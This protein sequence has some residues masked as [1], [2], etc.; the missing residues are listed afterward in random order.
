MSSST[1]CPRCGSRQ[2]ITTTT[3]KKTTKSRLWKITERADAGG[4]RSAPCTGGGPPATSGRPPRTRRAVPPGLPGPP[5]KTPPGAPRRGAASPRDA[6]VQVVLAIARGRVERPG[7]VDA[8]QHVREVRVTEKHDHGAWMDGAG[9]HPVLE[10]EI[11]PGRS[12]PGIQQRRRE[13]SGQPREE[14]RVDAGSRHRVADDD[15]AGVHPGEVGDP[16]RVE[17]TALPRT[18]EGR[19]VTGRQRRGRPRTARG[20]GAPGPGGEPPRPAERAGGQRPPQP[21]STCQ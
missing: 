17:G 14:G 18:G 3:T 16:P 20:P 10:R 7:R 19:Q 4:K 5:R 8:E 1:F 11:P 2:Y 15:E 13:L 6:R 9:D 21:T 12:A